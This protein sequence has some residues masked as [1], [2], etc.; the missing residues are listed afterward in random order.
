MLT[1]EVRQKGWDDVKDYF[2]HIAKY[3]PSASEIDAVP[4]FVEWK[5]NDR[6]K[7]G[8]LEWAKKYATERIRK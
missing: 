7:L 1:D 3:L 6:T 5:N 2:N 4:K 8:F